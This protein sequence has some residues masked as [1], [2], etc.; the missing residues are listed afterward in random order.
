MEVG[1]EERVDV[2]YGSKLSELLKEKGIS[3]RD[4]AN[5]AEL[6][7]STVSLYIS[8]K[9]TPNLKNHFKICKAINAESNFFTL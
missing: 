4:L 9:R 2:S 7:E 8:G 6:D 5:K 3:Q 1:C